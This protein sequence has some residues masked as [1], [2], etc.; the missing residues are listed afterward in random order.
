MLMLIA[1]PRRS[2][3]ALERVNTWF[4][5]HGRRLLALAS[6]GLGIYLVVVGVVEL[7]AG[8]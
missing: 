4:A 5:T 2:V 8:R 6:S 7:A 1:F 3:G